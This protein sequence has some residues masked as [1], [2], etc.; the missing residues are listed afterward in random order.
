MGFC[1]CKWHKI[2]SRIFVKAGCRNRSA[3]IPWKR[4]KTG[5]QLP[6]LFTLALTQ[7]KPENDF[8][9]HKQCGFSIKR[10]FVIKGLYSVRYWVHS[11][12]NQRCQMLGQGEVKIMLSCYILF[13][14]D[15]KSNNKYNQ[16]S[17]LTREFSQVYCTMKKLTIN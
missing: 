8:L 9:V 15:Y 5:K 17:F 16:T 10:L 13:F 12:F 14:S 3:L 1:P 7:D 11:F 4:E 2:Y 6:L